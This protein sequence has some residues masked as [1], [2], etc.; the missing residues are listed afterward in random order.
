VAASN[1]RS[2]LQSKA[3]LPEIVIGPLDDGN[4]DGLARRIAVP[5]LQARFDNNSHGIALHFERLP[6]KPSRPIVDD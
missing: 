6:I 4:F 3:Q 5:D 2:L 1:S